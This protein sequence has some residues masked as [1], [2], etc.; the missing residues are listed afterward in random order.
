MTSERQCQEG[1][2]REGLE[3]ATEKEGD[4]LSPLSFD[5]A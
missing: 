4:G 1:A 5:I 3:G 2:L